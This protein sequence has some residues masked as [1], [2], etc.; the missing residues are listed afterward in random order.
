MRTSVGEV[1]LKIGILSVMALTLWSR[2]AFALTCTTN[3]V[4]GNW[5]SAATWSGCGGG[6]PGATDDVV[7]ANFNRTYT[8]TANA[9]ALSLTFAGGTQNTTLTINGGVL[10]AVNGNTIVN[11]PTQNNRTKLIN[12]AAN[13]RLTVN[14]DVT[15]NGGGATNRV[16]G[17]IIGNNANSNVTVTGNI[18][19][20]NTTASVFFSGAGTM[21]VGGNFANGGTFIRG[22][23]TVIYNGAANQNVG[24][25]TYTNVTINKAGGTANLSGS[26]TIA[27]V[28]NLTQGTV[29]T[30]ANTLIT[31]ANCATSVVRTSGHVVG[32]LR[33][34]IPNNASICT[35]QIGDSTN[36]MPIVA[37][38]A[39]GT[40][41]G[42]LT[43]RTTTPDHSSLGTSG[44]DTA[45]SVNRFWTL[46]NDTAGN[47]VALPAA[48]FSATFTF[49]AGDVDVGAN[50]AAF[51]IERYIA[52]NWSPSAIGTRTAT[53]TQASGFTGFGDFAV[54]ERLSGNNPNLGR[55]NAFE[56]TTAAT[57]LRGIIKTKIAGTAAS[58]DI[59]HLNA[60]RTALENLTGS[61]ANRT[62]RV[63]L[64]NAVNNSGP[65]DANNCRNTWTVLQ[66]L[67]PNPVFVNNTARLTVTFNQ[68]NAWSDVRVRITYLGGG[69][70]QIG[71][72][73]DRFA[74]RPASL[75]AVSAS[76]TDWENAGTARTL[77]TTSAGGA[78]FHK[79]GR[80]FALTATAQNAVSVTTAN[81]A[82]TPVAMTPLAA[83]VGT[84]CTA[85]FGTVAVGTWA[86]VPGPGA[87]GTV[88]TTTASYSEV[89][90]FALRLEDQTFANVDVADST[91][92]ERYFSSVAVNVGRFV[93]DHF[94]V[95]YNTPQFAAA[96]GT[97]SYIGQPFVYATA[98][99]ITVTA[100]NFANA[101]T[102]NYDGAL[103]KI[104]NTS[105]TGK[106][107][108][109]ATGTLVVTGLPATDP[110][111]APT[112]AG[113]R[114]L[115]FGAGTGISFSRLVPAPL[116]APRDPFDADISLS[117]N[118][119]DGDGVLYAANPARFGQAVAGLGIA[120]ASSKQQRY[121]RV[122]LQNAFGSELVDLAMALTVQD[123]EN[124]T[125]GFRASSG[126]TCTALTL[127]PLTNFQGN[128]NA[129][130]T[131]VQDTGN[132]GAS[133]Q[134]CAVAGPVSKRFTEPPT[135]G[136]FNLYW[137][138]P[139][140][141]NDGSADVTVDLSAAPWFQFD[142]DGI[143]QGG[144]GN[145]YDDNPRAR[146]TFGI[147]KG[148]SRH[149]YL[150]ER[151]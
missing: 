65:L 138:A 126:D 99:I 117:I 29:V 8:V 77:N 128:L 147:Y 121:G 34:F 43:A 66:T 134:G 90:S 20:N 60:T 89:G 105:V 124:A 86:P 119:I 91:T 109:A 7:I 84:A 52:P 145:L 133:G 24:N 58:I 6:V 70:A 144:D 76:D 38:F 42:N 102:T 148:S 81:Y 95:S 26:S 55:F 36:Y 112:G 27:G 11:A 150:R 125:N 46:T 15:L 136:N 130:E 104:T 127:A 96:C 16:A 75:I 31:T 97:F 151:Y 137:R 48:G 111:I 72:S 49:V 118:V 74:I 115:T 69:P 123:Y 3:N 78:V 120:F 141:G 59:I 122:M 53:T 50:T 82:G 98:P 62:A 101:I 87:S 10:L 54:G 80:P 9:T 47:P 40:N 17:L 149:I 107:Y 67:A 92:A 39:A 2:P 51:E 18:N 93:P 142:W 13:G 56:T 5:N 44:L 146:A 21:S 37:V 25:Y 22:T 131:C 14:G 45:K 30:G 28:L 85:S 33:K 35:F 1:V 139:G 88:R 116:P 64:M 143:D 73:T 110:A 140:A 4:T 79:A 114:T 108:S 61:V 132:P 12:V 83:C 100:R 32:N 68:P 19:V 135:L 103:W 71:C 106:A 94:D 57:A 129:G 113:V 63:E 23:G 41:N